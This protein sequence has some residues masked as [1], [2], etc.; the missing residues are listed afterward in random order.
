MPPEDGPGLPHVCQSDTGNPLDHRKASICSRLLCA[1]PLCRRE[2]HRRLLTERF[3]QQGDSNIP[4]PSNV[5]EMMRSYVEESASKTTAP[6]LCLT[7]DLRLHDVALR[8][9]ATG[10]KS[11][12]ESLLILSEDGLASP[13]NECRS[14]SEPKSGSDSSSPPEWEKVGLHCVFS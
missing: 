2:S 4:L 12:G 5:L 1:A 13:E 9:S 6:F 8:L 11:D 3:V 14:Q 10:A 7:G